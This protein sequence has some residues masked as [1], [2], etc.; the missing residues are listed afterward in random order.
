[1]NTIFICQPVRSV[2]T[3]QVVLHSV[4]VLLTGGLWLVPLAVRA[5]LRRS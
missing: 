1:M 5:L 2:T 4:M 3:G